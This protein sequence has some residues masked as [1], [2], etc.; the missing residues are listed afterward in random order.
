MK[1][2]DV[3]SSAQSPITDSGQ[4]NTSTKVSVPFKNKSKF[5]KI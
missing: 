3:E 5:Q 1:L 2:Y 4:A